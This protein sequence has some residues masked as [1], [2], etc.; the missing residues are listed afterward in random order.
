[1][2]LS[3][4]VTPMYVWLYHDPHTEW[5]MEARTDYEIYLN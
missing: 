1:M 5:G 3:F 2:Q 4:I